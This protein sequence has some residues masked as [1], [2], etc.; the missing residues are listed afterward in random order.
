MLKD[1]LVSRYT[2]KNWSKNVCSGPNTEIE[3]FVKLALVRKAK[4]NEKER[5]TNEFIWSTLHGL[6][7]D[8]E[9]KKQ[10][11][12]LENLF[13]DEED[14]IEKLLVEGSPG[15]GKTKL[16]C[17]LSSMWAK[18]KLLQKYKLVIF[19]QLR[20]FQK[21]ELCIHDLIKHYLPGEKGKIIAGKLADSGCKN[22]LLILDGWDELAS[23]LRNELSY[24]HDIVS[25]IS[26]EFE[27]AS[28]MVTSRC[29]VSS[30]LRRL[31]DK[32]VEVLGFDTEQV[33]KY[34]SSILPKNKADMVFSHFR[35]FPNIQALSH[36]PLTLS[37]ICSILEDTDT[38]PST[39]TPLYDL[40]TRK[41][42][43]TNL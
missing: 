17:Y 1:K 43:L 4:L 19:V 6:L 39:L 7:D 22:T 33:E 2:K 36:I 31:V 9:K 27:N 41:I 26:C 23:D 38:L 5:A 42:L 25:G 32:H 3:L 29:T 12:K 14:T 28:V 16:A 10:L 34:V 40:Y 30:K 21:K 15:I 13:N 8:I 24:F 37:I 11:I 18:G 35:K 20:R